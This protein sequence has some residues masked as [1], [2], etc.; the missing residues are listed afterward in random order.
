MRPVAAIGLALLC[1]MS[2]RLVAQEELDSLGHIFGTEEAAEEDAQRA[3]NM[4]GDEE[5]RPSLKLITMISGQIDGVPTIGGGIIF[6]AASDH[7][8][9]VSA[10]HVLRRGDVAATDVT[11]RLYDAPDVI[12]QATVLPTYS[13]EKDIAVLSVA[14]PAEASANLCDLHFDRLTDPVRVARGNDAYAVGY[15]NGVPWSMPVLPDRIAQLV[16]DQIAFQSQFIS[17]GHSGGALID[18]DGLLIGLLLKDQQPFGLAARVESVLELLQSWDHPVK[19]THPA[20]GGKSRLHLAASAGDLDAVEA[21]LGDPCTMVG[22]RDATGE[23]ALH[24]AA[25]AGY[26]E[27]M[28]RLVSAGG[29]LNVQDDA[30][31]TP[32]HAAAAAGNLNVIEFLL[33]QGVSTNV[34]NRKGETALIAASGNGHLEAVRLAVA[35]GAEID[36]ADNSG[37]TALDHARL[38]KR[39]HVVQFLVQAGAVLAEQPGLVLLAVASRQGWP[40]VVREL[41]ARGIPSDDEVDLKD[42]GRFRRAAF[43]LQEAIHGGHLEVIHLLLAAGVDLTR[44]YDFEFKSR[45]RFSAHALASLIHMRNLGLSDAAKTLSIA[46]ALLEH[47]ANPNFATHAGKSAFQIALIQYED[48]EAADLLVRYGAGFSAG[49]DKFFINEAANAGKVDAVRFLIDRGTSPVRP[50]G[51]RYFPFLPLHEAASSDAPGVI[52]VAALLLKAGVDIETKD[53]TGDRPLE[54]AVRIGTSRMVK[55][56]LDQGADPHAGE[57]T[58]TPMIELL[59]DGPDEGEET[60][61]IR[62]VSYLIASGADLNNVRTWDGET[63]LHFAV[64]NGELEIIRRLVSTGADVAIRDKEGRAPHD[65]TNNPVILAALDRGAA[66][67]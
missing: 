15:P 6:W 37:L 7:L 65:L 32:L 21:L 28:S 5:A 27:V 47:G 49:S 43:P 44:K 42:D 62:K 10:N 39:R 29:R 17:Q 23:V 8:L 61:R 36:L 18:G 46:E 66:P 63:A 22:A 35:R 53:N 4:L 2:S 11:V 12:H 25:R 19:L 31:N 40:E 30:G 33:D 26:T 54:L 64:K 56:L 55:W 60:E 45:R 51:I 3:T 13:R 14:L 16:G 38:S 24:D 58:Y 20:A 59:R 48:L 41:L 50:K 67:D 52:D 34:Q 9:I 57:D 1:L